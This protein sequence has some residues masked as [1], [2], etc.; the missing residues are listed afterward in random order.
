MQNRPLRVRA[1]RRLGLRP[2][3]EK[4]WTLTLAPLLWLFFHAA[5]AFLIILFLLMPVFWLIDLS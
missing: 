1:A 4:L 5:L 3:R 2:L